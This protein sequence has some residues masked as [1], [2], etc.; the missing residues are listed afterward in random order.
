MMSVVECQLHGGS[1]SF[2]TRESISVSDSDSSGQSPDPSQTT[3]QGS[4]ETPL[5]SQA[6]PQGSSPANHHSNP[7]PVILPNPWRDRVIDGLI[8]YRIWWLLLACVL[9]AS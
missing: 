7:G 8:K 9:T 2:A 4:A 5:S 3:H 1:D 6:S